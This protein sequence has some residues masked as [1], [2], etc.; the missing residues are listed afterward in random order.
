MHMKLGLIAGLVAAASAHSSGFQQT[1]QQQQVGK[2]FEHEYIQPNV[3]EICFSVRPVASCDDQH[4]ASYVKQQKVG[5]H[6]LNKSSPIAKQFQREADQG[7]QLPL[8][9]KTQDIQAYVE[10]PVR[11]ERITSEEKRLRKETEKT[12]EQKIHLVQQQDGEEESFLFEHKPWTTK[13]EQEQEL[14]RQQYQRQLI[15]KNKQQHKQHQLKAGQ[16]VD[17]SDDEDLINEED[18]DQLQQYGELINKQ[19]SMHRILKMK[20]EQFDRL[21]EHLKFIA[22]QNR[23]SDK[24]SQQL[25]Q[26]LPQT[27][28]KTAKTIFETALEKQAATQ[29]EKEEL[30][31][32]YKEVVK[33]IYAYVVKQA[34]QMKQLNQVNAQITGEHRQQQFIANKIA[35]NLWY[36]IQR[37]L[38]QKQ[39]EEV[40]E[41]A[42]A[43][44]QQQPQLDR[45]TTD[46]TLVGQNKEQMK[47]L[48]KDL[49]K[50]IVAGLKMVNHNVGKDQLQ[51][52]T[53]EYRRFHGQE[54]EQEFRTQYPKLY[55]RLAN[56]KNVQ[57][58]AQYSQYNGQ[59]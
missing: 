24:W 20:D 42:T 2:V 52:Q 43:V 28:S 7:L 25:D 18:L 48:E 14:E 3:E 16:Q 58:W 17:E 10:V 8:E 31:E 34:L 30:Y 37:E 57:Q 46:E 23:R 39:V 19:T 50:T 51:G 15:R 11:C 12:A 22:H 40:R 29:Q 13:L 33:R 6:C 59:Y 4:V 55:N 47:Q 35:K 9:S 44:Q 38:T 54:Y 1:Q 41:I 36:K 56:I 21:M 45:M 49:T 32:Q 27:F 26:I 5:F 53:E